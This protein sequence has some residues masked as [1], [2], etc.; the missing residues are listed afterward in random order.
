[1]LEWYRTGTDYRG[2]ME[3]AENLLK[4]IIESAGCVTTSWEFPFDRMKVDDLFKEKALWKPSQD[5]DEDRYFRDW[6]QTIE[7]FLSSLKGVFV[8]DFPARLSSLSKIKKENPSVC[9]RFELFMGGVEIGNAYTE[10]TDYRE[11]VSRFKR[12]LEKRSHMKKSPYPLD[13]GFMESLKQG[14]PECG[15]MAVGIDRLVMVLLGLDSIDKV[16]TFPMGRL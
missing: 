12:A 15:G 14:L 16:Q 5:W 7:P 13:E 2:V 3:E 9:E 10:L 8:M 1:M 6:V 4:S 11:H